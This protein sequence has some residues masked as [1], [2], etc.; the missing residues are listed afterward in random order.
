M[1]SWRASMRPIVPRG[2][3]GVGELM[4]EEVG[5]NGHFVYLHLS[6]WN[7]YELFWEV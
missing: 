2:R 7:F 3:W 4:L 1:R 5:N 6:S